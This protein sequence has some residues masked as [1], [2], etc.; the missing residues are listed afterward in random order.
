MDFSISASVQLRRKRAKK[1]CEGVMAQ[2]GL[3]SS[4]ILFCKIDEDYNLE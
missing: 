4:S 2:R 3:L 1:Y